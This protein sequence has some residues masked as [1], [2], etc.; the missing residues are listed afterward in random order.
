LI[1]PQTNSEKPYHAYT[2]ASSVGFV[3]RIITTGQKIMKRKLKSLLLILNILLWLSFGWLIPA[4]S[5]SSINWL[6]Y[7][8]G[9]SLGKS[10]NKKIFLYFHADWCKPCIE[11][12]KETFQNPSIIEFLKA[13]FISI[14]VDFD[15]EKK[16]VSEYGVRGLPTI[17]FITETGEKIG[18]I[19]GYIS[20]ERFLVMLKNIVLF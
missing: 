8:E 20:P 9:M 15:R 2:S 17:W 11:M 19:L 14:K 12:E 6:G 13:N 3:A 4:Y 10:D 1:R 5:A 18:P 16:V 7:D